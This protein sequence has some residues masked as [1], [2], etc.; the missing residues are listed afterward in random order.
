ME[1]YHIG[2]DIGTSSIGWA[3]I[4]DD[5]KIKRKKGK[6]LIGVRLFKEG[7]TAAERRSFRTQRRRLNRRKW[8]LKL[9]EEIFDPYMAEVDEYFFARL[10]E[11]NLSPKDSNKKY[12]GSLLFP[13]ISDSNFYD[14]YP[15]IYHLR[16]DLMEKDK[17]FDLREIY[18]AIHH[19]VKY[20]GNFL[21][22]V[23]AKNYKNSGASIGFLLEEVNSLYK[24]IIGDE[25]V[26][27]L[28]SG[29]FED[30]EKIILDEETRNLDKQK[31]VGK[32][33][34][35]DKKKK[36]IVTAFSKA[37]L[38][39]KFNIEDLLLI[40]SDE[41]NKLTFNDENIDDIFNELSHSLDDNQMDLLTK[42][43]EIYFKFK[44]NM[45][46]PTGYTLS[47]SMI[48]KYEMHKAHLKMYK[49]FINTLNA[50]DR[51]IL[52][53]AYSDYINN[54]KAK[55]ANAQENFY[56]TIKKTIKDNNSDTA[57]KIIG[58]IDEGNFMPKQR[59]GENGVIPH[60]LHQ[61]ELDRIIENQA[62]Y[63]PW[64]AEE[65]PVEK[66]RKFAKYKLDELV[67]FRVPYYVG[68]LVDK[69]ESNKNEK[70]T[71]FAWMVR[72]AKGTITPW[73]FEN[74]V[75]RTESANRFIK[76]MTSKDTYIIGEDVLPASSL[77]YEKFKVLNELNNIKVN[78]K[79]LDVEQK[80]HVYLDLF[81][82]R[83]NVTKDNLATSLNCDVESITGLSD[84]E[85]F[86]SSLSSYI[87]LKAI[88]GNAV[89]DCNKNKDLEKI[90]EYSTIFEDGNIYKE[91]LSE[92]S[93]LTDEQI[94]KLSNIHFKGW[95]RL[96]KKLLTQITNENGERIIDALWNT[97]NNFIQIISDESIQA[98]LAEINGEYADKSNLEDILD[99]AYTSPQNKKAI[100]QVMKVVEDIEKAMK[101]KPTSIAIEF[102]RR[103]GKSK[104]TNT[105]Y[106]K[107]SETYE[108]I[109]DE[110]ISEY[111]LGK[112]QSKLDSKANNMRDIYYLYFM[113]LGR[114][115]YT[116]EKIN[117][118]ELHQYYD[119]D[120]IFPRSFIK[121][122]SLN[123]RVLTRKEINNNEKADRTA[124]DLYA[125]KMGDFW[126][127][128]RKQGLITEKKYKNLLTRTDSIDKYTKQSFIKR[129]LVETSQVV[130]MAANILQDK[131]SNTKI[132]EV[133]ARLNSD[134]RK[135][136]ELIK[137]REVN[138]YHH[139][140]DGYLTIFIGQ[141]LYKTYPKLRSYF[142]YDD[143][144]KLDSN[145]LKHMDKFNFI[146]KLEDKKAEDV[147]DNVNNEFILNVPKMKDYIQKIYNYKYM[148]ISKEVTTESGA[149]YKETKYKA[150]GM[151]LIP[152]KQNKP[153]NIYGGY[154]EKRNSYMMLVKIKKKKETI[155]K[156]V[157]IPRLLSDELDR[158][159]TMS[160]KQLL[161]ETIAR[162]SLS[163]TEQNFKIILDKIYY[164]Q[165]VIDGNQKYTLG[166]VIYKHNAMQLHLSKQALEILAVGKT[167]SREVKDEELIAVYE[168]I[169]LVVNKYFE[170]YDIS[171]FRQK[172]NDGLEIFKELPIYNI[173][174]NNKIKKIGKFEVLNRILIGLHA[175]AA[176]ADLSVL[177]FKDLGK[178]QVNGGIK[179]SPD[180]K[181]I[182]QSPTGI[183]SR[184]VRVKDLG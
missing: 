114:D 161:L 83:K 1:R 172:L 82:T 60:Q 54:E 126:R 124:A 52:K 13:D 158:L 85:K 64:L 173:Y 41:K 45:I 176:R 118:D 36:N 111:E 11:S 24:D 112:L 96:S 74:L 81:T 180:A 147:Y 182:Y 53:N 95:G 68:P 179:L 63:Y 78:K 184:A 57:K 153:I 44:L 120:H 110:L 181:L 62:K 29:K 156:I 178:L 138:D 100:R 14:K 108:K 9:L 37:I 3:V 135:E 151:N 136:Y 145:Y 171:K 59:T 149:F 20:R 150:G 133:R 61:I 113:Q 40:E 86:N 77:L 155:Y 98:K 154:K 183:F 131:Y 22:K 31:S 97:S 27:I 130:K 99:E 23:P 91:K 134:L 177:G 122:N 17:K 73:N 70:E 49:E 21:E 71:K 93:W 58:L 157:G 84:N 42:T 127:K 69:T 8:R 38:G 67:T 25:S 6:N 87:D 109:T 2:L 163:K 139:A 26:A 28:N 169:L 35:E 175:N 107:I 117:I 166:S 90:I 165:L 160:E 32:L 125:V 148:L 39:Y 132:I 16:R 4:G 164:G 167:K 34:V 19:I 76:R 10:K 101:C 140:I 174:E 30:V 159:N 104:L 48:E 88:L 137:N 129:Q 79:K 105:R 92:I 80:Q 170:L 106:K 115:M 102:T 168:E 43:R 65:N 18:L 144:K 143:F 12:L 123:N 66:N 94:E 141:Y 116:G 15:T 51:K 50:K 152:I 46:V 89:D 72:K 5:F 47:E 142:V 75:D 146:W 121:D 56:K 128:L 103:K 33:L 119:I 55:A 162:T 7:D